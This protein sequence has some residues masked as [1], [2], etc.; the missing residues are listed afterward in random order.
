MSLMTA[1]A[2]LKKFSIK[3]PC[4][5]DIET[6]PDW[7]NIFEN[8]NPLK[9]EIGFGMG[10]FLIEM[11]TREPHSNFIGIDFTKNGVQSL[12]TK[13]KTC[14]LG[15]IR[16]IHGDARI[17]LSALFRDEELETIYVNFPDPWPKKRH[18]KRR[19]INP[20]LVNLTV[21]K[22]GPGG[23]IYLAT[24]SESYAQQIMEY[25][26]AEPFCQNMNQPSGLLNNRNGLPKTK[27]EKSFIYAGDKTYYLDYSRLI[28]STKPK[29]LSK[30]DYLKNKSTPSLIKAEKKPKDNDHFL[31][32][33]FQN[34]EANAEDACDLKI[35]ADRIAEAG[36]K[37]WAE[38]VYK[39]AEIKGRDSLDFNWLAYSIVETLGD[40]KWARSIYTKAEE[41]SE[42][43]LELN[44]VA[45]SI[46][47]TLNDK[48][49]VKKLYEKATNMPGNIRE[50]CD[51]AD[52]IHETLGEISWVKKIFNLAE[53]RVV[54][55][56]D[57][58][59][60]ADVMYQK[61]GNKEKSKQLFKKAE[62]KA[63]DCSDFQSLAE[64]IYKNFTDK[65]WAVR[66]Y[67]KAENKAQSS[68]DFCSLAD[69][70]YKN[71]NDKK[72]AFRLYKKA[73]KQAKTSC[74]L[75][76]LADNL[77]LE[78]GDLGWA[79]DLYAKSEGEA[80]FFYEFRRLAE[81]LFKNLGDKEWARENYKKAASNATY[82][83]EF[84][85]LATSLHKNLKEEIS[86][87]LV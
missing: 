8:S 75:R 26:D 83:S 19:L 46:F 86:Y 7:K 66:L 20:K 29:N 69:S 17:K 45:Y 65:K 85:C 64:S 74:E 33:K 38:N 48:E 53:E 61:M 56:S 43:S 4:F 40:I 21:Q 11:A 76:D 68:R 22:L 54:E 36:D 2:S 58:H 72:W 9:L 57:C 35:I 28:L 81:C 62:G 49:W 67:G 87:I 10:D 27:Y 16:V 77:C 51:L 63:T 50:L 5:L 31:T 52:S 25:F 71:L 24:D 59:E 84:N 47:E 18:L 82:T 1:R 70:L 79:K 14:Q 3:D 80:K 37:N 12:L 13:I 73:E 78:L 23:H 60:L 55:Y 34:D 6:A 30:K 15:N 32:K 42:S 39:K 41:K 44:W